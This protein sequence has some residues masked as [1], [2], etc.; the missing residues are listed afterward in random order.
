MSGRHLPQPALLRVEQFDRLFRPPVDGP[1]Q[2]ERAHPE[3]VVGAGLQKHF[4]DGVGVGVAP[5][6]D[7]HHRGRLVGEHVDGVARR[8]LHQFA[9]RPFELDLVEAVLFDGEGGRQGPVFAQA[10]VGRGR[11]VEH[12]P[13]RRGA[14]G[15]EHPHEDFGAPQHGDVSAVLDQPRFEPGVGGEAVFELQ[16]VDVRQVDDVD[17]ERRRAHARRVDVVVGLLA[18]VEQHR[19]EGPDGR[20][21]V[22]ENVLRNQRNRLPRGLGGAAHEQVDVVRLETGEL[23]GHRQVGPA[24]DG[25]VARLDRDAVGAGLVEVSGGGHQ[26][27]RAVLQVRRPE[28]EREQGRGRGRRQPARGPPDL[29]PLDG[30]AQVEVLTALDGRAHEPL[31]EGRRVVGALGAV[32]ALGLFESA[33]QARVERRLVLFEVERHPLVGHPPG[34]GPHHVPERQ[35][36]Q[37]QPRQGAECDD[38]PRR[39]PEDLEAVRRHEEGGE[40]GRQHDRQTAQGDAHAPPV[41]HAADDADQVV[42]AARRPQVAQH[43]CPLLPG[44]GT[45]CPSYRN[46]CPI[47]HNLCG[48]RPCAR[49]HDGL[50]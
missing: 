24:G 1:G 42:R 23:R 49:G 30:G 5:G 11:L 18:D 50:L 35:P 10:Q 2:A 39:E 7:E 6:L 25:D 15:R 19:L 32:S 41:P 38:R 21:P 9:A 13:P 44:T 4:V 45:G 46:P 37:G 14:H 34:Q 22:V 40:T 16:A 29:L 36:G 12:Q 3:V 8:R 48:G 43:G 17:G 47:L 27:R 20:R 31:D 26:R 33:Q 28:D